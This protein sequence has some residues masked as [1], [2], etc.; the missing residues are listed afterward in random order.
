MEDVTI[1]VLDVLLGLEVGSRTL[2]LGEHLASGLLSS[3]G[4]R[5]D[6][7]DHQRQLRALG[8]RVVALGNGGQED[9][10]DPQRSSGLL[11]HLLYATDGVGAAGDGTR[12]EEVAVVHATE[13]IGVDL[14]VGELESALER[15]VLVLRA[16]L[17]ARVPIHNSREILIQ[18]TPVVVLLRENEAILGANE[19]GESVSTI[20]AAS[21]IEVAVIV[22]RVET[23]LLARAVERVAIAHHVIDV[24]MPEGL[25]TRCGNRH[26]LHL[27]VARGVEVARTKH[28]TVLRCGFKRK[29]SGLEII[30]RLLVSLVG[31]GAYANCLSL[32]KCSRSYG[33]NGSGKE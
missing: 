20:E 28:L 33:C 25:R 7:G 24:L 3:L 32:R 6:I 17:H 5:L 29:A 4:G 27:V 18:R 31:L 19:G 23:A 1:L 16:A 12:T 21:H 26:K 11:Q 15:L 22:G 10:G 30:D 2:H 9:V 14:V 13:A 8:Q